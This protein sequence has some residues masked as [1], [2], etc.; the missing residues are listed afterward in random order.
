MEVILPVVTKLD[1]LAEN[2]ALKNIIGQSRS[3][4]NFQEVLNERGIVLIDTASNRIGDDAAG[5][6]TAL[7]IDS[8]N[9]AIRAQTAVADARQRP[10]VMVIIDELQKLMGVNYGSFLAELQK[11]GASFV[12]GTQSL[13]QLEPTTEQAESSVLSNTDTLFV[14]D[15]FAGD[16]KTLAHNLD[17]VVDSTDIINLPAH[18]AYL[19]TQVDANRTQVVFVRLL[20][21]VAADEI[22]QQQIHTQVARYSLPIIEAQRRRESFVAQ[23]YGRDRRMRDKDDLGGDASS[24]QDLGG[25]NAVGYDP[26]SPIHP[27]GPSRPPVPPPSTSETSTRPKREIKAP[28]GLKQS[29]DW[30][31]P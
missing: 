5:L 31:K 9:Y 30:G 15:T 16:A 12:M 21:P 7:F 10:R 22:A 29:N 3:T 8:L 11:M 4:L 24:S 13:A 27:K 18:T 6:L 26:K 17:D 1:R 23:W 14:F 25:A 20:P 28:T 2:V 19:K